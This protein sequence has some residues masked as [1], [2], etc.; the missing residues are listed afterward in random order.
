MN[1]KNVNKP[2]EV[3]TVLTLANNGFEPSNNVFWIW[4]HSTYYPLTI[5][6]VNDKYYFRVSGETITE[7]KSEKQLK[8]L[9]DKYKGDE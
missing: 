4:F 2:K 3:L 7:V 1:F 8:D 6:I 9:V 5:A